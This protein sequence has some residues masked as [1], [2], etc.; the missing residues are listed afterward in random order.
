MREFVE[1]VGS[2]VIT[3]DKIRSIALEVVMQSEKKTLTDEE[4]NNISQKIVEKA[5]IELKARLK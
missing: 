3:K 2:N 1:Q 5:R 4:I